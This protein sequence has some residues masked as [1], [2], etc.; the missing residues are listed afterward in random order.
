M[1][2]NTFAYEQA[3]SLERAIEL[4]RA[5]ADAKFL[6]GGHS[7]IPMMKMR[8]ASPSKL[9]DISGLD[10]LRGI[11]VEGHHVVVGALTP[12]REV[13]NNRIIQTYLPALAEAARHIGDLQVR[14]RGTVGGNLAHADPASDLPAITL[15]YDAALTV[16]G[17]EGT[18][19]LFCE[20]FFLGPFMTALPEGN[21]ILS[22]SF[23]IPPVGT[24]SVYVKYPHPASGY[25]VVGVAAIIGKDVDGR[26]NYVRIGV[27]GAGDV[28]YRA[29]T[30]EQE[31]AG[32]Q[33]TESCILR[34]SQYAADDGVIAED[35]F[36]SEAYRKHLCAVYVARAL[37]RFM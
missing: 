7:L 19:T 1:I 12:H 27:T 28:V 2:P 5:D 16:L 8:L 36:A 22:V 15:A 35:L 11:K 24:K 10:E 17:P 13:A 9:I 31:L 32:N 26:V 6:A 25:A 4:S 3:N 34:A 18:E 14:N 37:K 23:G 20:D 21:L 33:L 30:V 29:R